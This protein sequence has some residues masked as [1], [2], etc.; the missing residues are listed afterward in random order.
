MGLLNKLHFGDLPHT[1]QVGAVTA[2]HRWHA[3]QKSA[4]KTERR[5]SV[6]RNFLFIHLTFDTVGDLCKEEHV[7]LL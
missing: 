4:T 2:G 3:Q 7:R 1:V 5:R 6:S